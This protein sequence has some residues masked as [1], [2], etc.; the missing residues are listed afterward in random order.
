MENVT[1][2]IVNYRTLD[3]TR[4]CLTSLL[5]VYPDAAALIFDNGSRD[6]SAEYIRAL[7]AERENVRAIFSERN[8]FHGPALDKSLRACSTRYAF[9]LDSD[10][11]VHRGG[12]LESMLELFADNRTYAVGDLRFKSRLGFTFRFDQPTG[13][14]RRIRYIHPCAAAF[15]GQVQAATTLRASR[16][17]LPS[18]HGGGATT[19][20][21]RSRFPHSRFRG[22]PC[23]AG[24]RSVMTP[25]VSGLGSVN[26]SRGAS[27][28]PLA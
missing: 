20:F 21:P 26:G 6:E 12:F 8:I 3:L 25:M 17:A 9:T 15:G 28:A 23:R 7:S 11:Y 24:H 14:R 19:R 27:T 5:R 22:A 18:K 1:F 16:L 13:R 10:C 4:E 2:V